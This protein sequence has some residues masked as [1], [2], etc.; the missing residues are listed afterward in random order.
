VTS[1]GPYTLDAELELLRGHRA[2]VLVTKDSGGTYTWPKLA[3]A[4]LLG[5]PVVVVRRP[6]GP[7]A[8]P[9]VHEVAAAFAWVREL[10]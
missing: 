6:P 2:D 7:A 5:V 9:T 4:R 3:A 1:R 10:S 8:V